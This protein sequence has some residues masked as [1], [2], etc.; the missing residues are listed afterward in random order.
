LAAALGFARH[1]GATLFELRCLLD[2]FDLVG[3]VDRSGL[4]DA[5]GRFGGDTRWAEFARAQE[6]LS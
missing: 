2:L 6:I 4:A 1:Q 5:V 3:D